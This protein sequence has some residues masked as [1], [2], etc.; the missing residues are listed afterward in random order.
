MKSD[1]TGGGGDNYWRGMA[2]TDI[3]DMNS[4]WRSVL[5]L[6]RPSRR[7]KGEYVP[8]G[9]DLLFLERGKVRLTH[10]S[11]EGTEKTLW[12]IR[13]GCIFAE[14]PF[15]VPAEPDENVCICMTNCLI[16]AFSTESVWQIS[17]ERPDLLHNLFKSMSR[18]MKILSSHASSLSLDSVL[19]RICKF[20][21]QRLVP[22]SNPLVANIGI[23]RQ[24]MASL[25]GVHRISLYRVLRQEEERGLFGPVTGGKMA[26][27]RPQEFYNSRFHA[28]L[29]LC[30]CLT[31][32]LLYA[33]LLLLR[34]MNYS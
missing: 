24:E 7:V 21:S 34:S 19:V 28:S 11:L 23:S 22:G 2:F 14:A 15:F 13:E 17:R 32:D 30:T 10:Q 26:I 5:S 1:Q 6:A 8:L 25:I 12:Y 20:L 29:H 18:K 9:M 3:K 31:N 27:L 4:N 33:L 16:Y